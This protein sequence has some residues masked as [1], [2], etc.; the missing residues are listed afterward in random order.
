LEAKVVPTRSRKYPLP[1]T[2]KPA[3]NPAW[4]NS[5]GVTRM[6]SYW[7]NKDE[8]QYKH[9]KNSELDEGRSEKRAEQIA[10]ATVNKQRSN[11]G[12][13]KSSKGKRS[14]SK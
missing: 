12:R 5:P 14:G 9:V 8:R 11:E 6:P 4:F 2:E 3:H 7:S 10:A 13:T 1:E